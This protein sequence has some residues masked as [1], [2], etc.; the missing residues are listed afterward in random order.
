MNVPLSAT[1]E[2]LLCLCGVCDRLH[3]STRK[4]NIIIDINSVSIAL[5]EQ[6]V[7]ECLFI[8][9]IHHTLA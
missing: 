5:A 2:Q 7:A 4:S 9:C 6:F 3:K 8:E 1:I